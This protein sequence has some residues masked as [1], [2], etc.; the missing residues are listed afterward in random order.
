SLPSC[1]SSAERRYQ[2]YASPPMGRKAEAGA[3]KEAETDL[4]HEALERSVGPP[5][6][7]K[8]HLAPRGRPALSRARRRR[9]ALGRVLGHGSRGTRRCRAPR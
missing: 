8:P 7:S 2:R 3:S 1:C 5:L 9:S 6:R 4:L